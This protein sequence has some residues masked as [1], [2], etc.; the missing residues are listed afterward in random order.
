MTKRWSFGLLALITW[1]ASMGCLGGALTPPVVETSGEPSEETPGSVAGAPP[2]GIT[3]PPTDASP[4][5]PPDMATPPPDT[6]KPSDQPGSSGSKLR[7]YIPDTC[8]NGIVDADEECDEG[9]LT[10]FGKLWFEQL[11]LAQQPMTPVR[12]VL[13]AVDYYGL[14][15]GSSHV[16]NEVANESRV[17]LYH[18]RQTGL[19]SVIVNHGA[20]DPS[21]HGRVHIDFDFSFAG[22]VT[23]C[24]GQSATNSLCELYAGNR[25][26]RATWD[27]DG[28]SDGL[29]L[30]NGETFMNV[31]VEPVFYEGIDAWVLVNGTQEKKP[32]DASRRMTIRAEPSSTCRPD[33][34]R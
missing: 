22:D 27:F 3:H 23:L 30:G 4:L 9:L 24:D 25:L 28:E 14:E 5:T 32:L 19:F 26:L 10:G 16:G 33:C 15:D 17:T 21:S 1:K 11:G 34:A 7:G 2:D 12:G 29:I 31:I 20:A 8:G 13:S 18:S 6:A